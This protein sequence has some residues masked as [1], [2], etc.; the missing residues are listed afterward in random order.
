MIYVLVGFL[1]GFAIPYLA[2][3][4]AK[5]MPATPGYALYR[6]FKQN[7]KVSKEK[8]WNNHVYRV[9]C[10]RYFMRSFGWAI[11]ATATIFLATLVLPSA[12]MPWIS[13]FIIT[14]Y[15][16]MEI[17][18]RMFLLPDILTVPLLISGFC[19]AV[20]AGGISGYDFES[21][22]INSSLGAAAGYIIPITASLFLIK[23]YPDAFGGGDIKL[24]AAVG[25]W[26]GL[27]NISY[28]ILL[29]CLVFAV[30]CYIN[31]QRQGAFGPSIVISSLIILFLL[32][33]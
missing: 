18:R 21:S 12:E 13:F 4:F 22:V 20:F 8:R 2:R 25:A 15:I 32:T 26:M 5:F 30:S 28:V 29:S 11:T 9:L 10:N 27:T 31:K 24:L 23:K 14:L 7:K 16:L 19:Y 33:Y 6:I 3:R 17:D 1:C